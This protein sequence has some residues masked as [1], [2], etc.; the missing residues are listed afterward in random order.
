MDK[1]PEVSLEV[2][3]VTNNPALY[4]IEGVVTRDLLTLLLEVMEADDT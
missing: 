3:Q 2:E 1:T 4:R